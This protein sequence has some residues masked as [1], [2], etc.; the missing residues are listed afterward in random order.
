MI[1]TMKKTIL[2]F[3]CLAYF[4]ISAQVTLFDPVQAPSG[5]MA[6]QDFETNNNGLDCAVADDFTVPVGETWYI[7]SIIF[8]GVY[9]ATATV[10]EAGIVVKIYENNAGAFGPLVFSDSINTDVD[11]N[12]D[13][14]L[15]PDWSDNP[16]LMN[17]GSYWIVAQARKDFI[18]TTGGTGGQW[19][20]TRDTNL[21]GDA[22]MW[23]NPGNGFGTGCNTWAPI[24]S[25]VGPIINSSDS[26]M[27]F[28]MFG[29]Y[30]PKP[31]GVDIGAD[32]TFCSGNSIV[33]DG[34][35][36]TP[37]V[38][39][40]W[41][42]GVNSQTITVDST[43]EYEITVF[44]SSTQCSVVKSV[45]V[46][47]LTTPTYDIPD[48]TTCSDALPF[49]LFANVPNAS[50]V[51]EDGSTGPVRFV[52]QAG[53]Y[54]ATYNGNNG[55]VGSDQMTLTIA[56]L[57]PVTDPIGPIDLCFGESF[58]A[59]VIGSYNEYDWM[60]D[61]V[62]IST[63]D[64]LV[65]SAGGVYVISVTAPDGC[66]G[67][68]ELAVIER[69]V[70][71]PAIQSQIA[72]GFNIQ[73]FI[74]GS[75]T[76][77]EWS[78]GSTASSITVTQNGTYT[79]TVIDEFGCEG[80]SAT[81][82]STVGIEDPIAQ[83]VTVY[84]NPAKDMVSFTFPDTWINNASVTLFDTQGRTVQ[85]FTVNSSN[86][87]LNLDQMSNGVYLIQFNSP[88]GVGNTSLIVTE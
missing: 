3:L 65:I 88:E 72:A 41:N 34:S 43:G 64:S 16:I 52:S 36:T 19:Y 78:N 8:Y 14:W 49:A 71:N 7:D 82:V 80:S 31:A 2:L 11:R 45:N 29:C 20:W 37:N 56:D 87:S 35:S 42:T 70:P 5:G 86:H 27:A 58:T 83:Q 26:G 15:T 84:P 77:Y 63:S 12:E 18:L 61:S 10:S 67:T 74:S 23:I 4:N 9:S 48:A 81:T 1:Y 22:S 38:T 50:V 47:V 59:G 30:G 33:L 66:T 24:Y 68:A 40:S 73:L 55:C 57:E 6:A 54:T 62:T 69:P 21:V 51:W 39:Y 60:L 44:D 75:Y 76:S 32:T 25:C 79:V 17:A 53:T 85:S 13:G 28:R 46:T